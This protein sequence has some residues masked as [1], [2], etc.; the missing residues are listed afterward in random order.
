MQSDILIQFCCRVRGQKPLQVAWF[1]ESDLI[2]DENP[3]FRTFSQG[4]EFV[5][6]VKCTKVEL[7]GAYSAVV[8]NHKGEEWAHFDLKVSP[9]KPE[10]VQPT[11]LARHAIKVS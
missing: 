9:P 5:L 7:A 8:Y 4:S 11:L 2:R 1:R 6:E 3:L 10:R